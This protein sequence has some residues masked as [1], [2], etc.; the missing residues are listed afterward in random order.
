MLAKRRHDQREDVTWRQIL[1]Q[2]RNSVKAVWKWNEESR[3][4][5][6]FA[7][8]ALVSLPAGA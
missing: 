2:G 7:G 3:E 1:A 8:R 4:E 5:A 6:P